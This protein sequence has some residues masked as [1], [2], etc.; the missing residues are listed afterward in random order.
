MKKYVLSILFLSL[1]N[2]AFS[3]QLDSVKYEYGHLFY[4]T[5]GKGET[6]V[7]LSGGPGNNA[8]QLE[9]VALRLAAN[10]RIIL[11]EQR[12]TGLSIP[13]KFDSTTITLKAAIRDIN[14]V[15]KHL[16]LQKTILVGHSY[17]ASLAMIYASQFPQKVKSL[18]L[19]AP[20]YFGMGWPMYS[21]CIDNVISK[22]GIQEKERL[23]ELALKDDSVS[24]VEKDEL[25][26]LKRLPY[27]FDKAKI[28]SLMPLIEGNINLETFSLML[29][30]IMDYEIDLKKDLHK[31]LCPI[32]IICGR[33]DFLTYVAYELKLA[34]SKIKLHWISESAHF[35]MH[36]N[37]DEFYAVMDNVLAQTKNYRNK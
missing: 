32:N 12:G 6:I 3:Q 25:K 7:M 36:E 35:P 34:N 19:I 18:V 2:S 27:I 29:P 1:I 23:F 21:I 4:H 22:L 33:Q 14:L 5:Y 37:P 26:K 9:S 30:N 28:D 10:Y 15:L 17:G 20:G 13:T 8:L 11:L 16:K 24:V 31:I